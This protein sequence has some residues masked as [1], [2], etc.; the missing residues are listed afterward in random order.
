MTAI[1][2]PILTRFRSALN[3][4]YGERI[5]RVV[6]FGSPRFLRDPVDCFASLAVTRTNQP[7]LV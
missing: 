6:L 2:D 5:E 1:A 4:A 7:D 3:E